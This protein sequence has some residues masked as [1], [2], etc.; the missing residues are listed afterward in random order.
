MKTYQEAIEHFGLVIGEEIFDLYMSGAMDTRVRLDRY[1]ETI[2]F[3]YGLPEDD[4]L[5]DLQNQVEMQ[6]Q[7][8]RRQ[9]Y[10]R[11]NAQK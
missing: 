3:I 11:V 5:E 1:A 4:V 2:S 6:E 7:Q 8:L 9:H 10:A